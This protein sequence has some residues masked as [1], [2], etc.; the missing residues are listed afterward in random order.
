MLHNAINSLVVRNYDI[1]LDSTTQ[2]HHL[3]GSRPTCKPV[4]NSFSNTIFSDS[5]GGGGLIVNIFWG[6]R[7]F[8]VGFRYFQGG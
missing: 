1:N 7:F 5:G 8:R 2:N 3:R 6:L 4:V